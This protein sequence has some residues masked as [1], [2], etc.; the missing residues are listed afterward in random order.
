MSPLTLLCLP[1]RLIMLRQPAVSFLSNILGDSHS[2]LLQ[3]RT[4]NLWL[5]TSFLFLFSNTT[6][7]MTSATLISLNFRLLQFCL[8][9]LETFT[10]LSKIYS[11]SNSWL[12]AKCLHNPFKTVFLLTTTFGTKVSFPTNLY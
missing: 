4:T 1:R 8:S 11:I 9:F 10:L 7:A 3:R 2:S 6:F 12:N 5:T